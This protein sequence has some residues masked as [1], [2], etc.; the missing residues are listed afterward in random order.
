MHC[1]QTTVPFVGIGAFI[2]NMTCSTAY[3]HNDLWLDS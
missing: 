2:F 1:G 3:S